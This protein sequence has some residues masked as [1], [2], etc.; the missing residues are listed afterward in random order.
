ML[1]GGPDNATGTIARNV[2]AQGIAHWGE[3]RRDRRSAMGI[4]K[5][6]YG[7]EVLQSDADRP[8]IER[9][10]WEQNVTPGEFDTGAKAYTTAL[11]N[12]LAVA[13]RGH[14]RQHRRARRRSRCCPT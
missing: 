6:P 12:K 1:A 7:W 8:F 2:E 11:D 3:R 5:I 13:G 9:S 4:F 10:W 14:Q